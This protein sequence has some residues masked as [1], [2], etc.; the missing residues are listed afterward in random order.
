[1]ISTSLIAAVLLTAGSSAAAPATVAD[2]CHL[3]LEHS[4]ATFWNQMLSVAGCSQ[5][6]AILQVDYPDELGLMVEQLERRIAPAL[7]LDLVMVQFAPDD[8]AIRAASQI[9]MSE[10]GLVTRARASISTTTPNS[11]ELRRELE[12][13]LAHALTAA[14]LAFEGIDR[15]AIERTRAV[16]DPVTLQAVRNARAMLKLLGPSRTRNSYDVSS[17]GAGR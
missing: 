17:A 15:A 8:V 10:L 5:D 6:T 13:M 7:Q 1:M 4:I 9:G 11:A 12:P 3:D 2:V 14:R 16:H